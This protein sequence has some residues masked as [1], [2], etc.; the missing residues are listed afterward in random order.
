MPSLNELYYWPGGNTALKPEYGWN[1]DLGYH[2]SCQVGRFNIKQDFDWFDRQIH[3]WIIW[4][5]GAIWTPYN[6]AQVHSRGTETENSIDLPVGDWKFRFGLSTSYVL[7]TTTA[8][9]IPADGSIGKQLPYTPRYN[10]RFNFDVSFKKI[11]LGY[12]H[13]YSG[14][15]FITTDESEYLSP[16]Q[17][18]NIRLAW[19]FAIRHRDIDYSLQCNN[20]WNTRYQVVAYRPMPGT[21]WL[22]GLCIRI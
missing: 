2:F 13:T 1:A 11:Q 6:I 17:T 5:G 21:N 16:Y 7:A 22:T 20:I 10:Y 3:D 15:R 9:Y 19:H 4:M 12:N 8:S 18:G 14:Y